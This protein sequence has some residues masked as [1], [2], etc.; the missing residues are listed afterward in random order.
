LAEIPKNF[1]KKRIY[2][3][4]EF[5]DLNLDIDAILDYPIPRLKMLLEANHEIYK[6]RERERTLKAARK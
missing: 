3:A 2:I 5:K 6:L 1:E 4:E